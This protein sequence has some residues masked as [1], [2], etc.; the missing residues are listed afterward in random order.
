MINITLRGKELPCICRQKSF[1]AAQ[2]K[3]DAMAKPMERRE[4]KVM[5]QRRSEEGMQSPIPLSGF[6]FQTP[7]AVRAKMSPSNH[8]RPFLLSS[9]HI[10]VALSHHDFAKETKSH[11]II[12]KYNHYWQ[13][14]QSNLEYRD[15]NS[16]RIDHLWST[17][18]TQHYNRFRNNKG[19]SLKRYRHLKWNKVL[20]FVWT[21][22]LYVVLRARQFPTS[23]R[24]RKT[25]IQGEHKTLVACIQLDLPSWHS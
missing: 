24:L 16:K 23:D 15:V 10:C 6:S 20:C 13:I 9:S 21:H 8:S 7:V 18:G 12:G 5:K 1:Y 25:F 11:L 22:L 19:I 4:K 3:G 2:F 14:Q 17:G